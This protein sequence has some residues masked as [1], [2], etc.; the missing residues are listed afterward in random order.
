MTHVIYSEAATA[1]LKEILS[2]LAVKVGRSTV[3][4]FRDQ[5]RAVGRRLANIPRSGAPRPDLGE[6]V[7]IAVVAP[8]VVIYRHIEAEDGVQ[9]L[10]MLHGKRDITKRLI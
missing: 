8:Y 7:R 10:R 5:F 6:N 2:D 4:K 1:D 3:L 9:I